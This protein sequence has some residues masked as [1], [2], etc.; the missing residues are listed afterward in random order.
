MP[1]IDSAHSEKSAQQLVSYWAGKIRSM[2]AEDIAGVIM[3]CTN[4]KNDEWDIVLDVYVD[5]D[6]EAF[7]DFMRRIS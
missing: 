1:I 4:R 6:S 5:Q 2:G 7:R 3:I